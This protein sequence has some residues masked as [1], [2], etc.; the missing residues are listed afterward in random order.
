MRTPHERHA[1]GAYARPLNRGAAD[2]LPLAGAGSRSEAEGGQYGIGKPPD[3][4]FSRSVHRSII[5]GWI[6]GIVTR[7]RS[8]RIHMIQLRAQP[9]HLRFKLVD[10]PD[11]LEDQHVTDIEFAR[12]LA[13]G[14]RHI[15]RLPGA[16]KALPI[17]EPCLG[18]PIIG[19][20]PSRICAPRPT[21]RPGR[22]PLPPSSTERTPARCVCSRSV[23]GTCPPL[24]TA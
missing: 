22:R 8:A 24:G 16:R 14:Q 17:G 2:R 20:P 4:S 13:A 9:V 11:L 1:C 5:H 18:G 21:G 6:T 10:A 19:T 7:S 15:D 23:P 3:Y 12:R